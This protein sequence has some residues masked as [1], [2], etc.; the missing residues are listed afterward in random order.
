MEKKMAG[1]VLAWAE[2]TDSN[3]IVINTERH[4]NRNEHKETQ[5]VNQHKY[6]RKSLST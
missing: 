1:A 4:K 5:S 6:R 3:K 2:T